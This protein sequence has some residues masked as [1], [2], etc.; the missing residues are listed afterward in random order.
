[1]PTLTIQIF[2]HTGETNS[3]CGGETKGFKDDEFVIESDN[4]A[5]CVS[6]DQRLQEENNKFKELVFCVKGH[7]V[8]I[9]T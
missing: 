6:F 8:D 7:E 2:R 5:N 1:M 3:D 9:E 4:H